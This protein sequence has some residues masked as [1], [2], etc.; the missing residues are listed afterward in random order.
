MN[1]SAPTGD[2]S[3]ATGE[4]LSATA[5]ASGSDRSIGAQWRGGG[6]V[7]DP[8]GRILLAERSDDRARKLRAVVIVDEVLDTVEREIASYPPGRGGGLVGPI[9]LP[10]IT[11][12]VPDPQVATGAA[13]RASSA[14]REALTMIQNADANI[15]FKGILH[16]SPRATSNPSGDGVNV[17]AD[18][19]RLAPWFGRYVNPI[20]TH[21]YRRPERHEV[22]LP[23][24]IMSVYVSERIAVGRAG[25]YPA[26]VQVLPIGRDVT[27]LAVVLGGRV[28]PLGTVDVDGMVFVSYVV[29]AGGFELNLLFAPTY[30][31]QSPIVLVE[32]GSAAARSGLPITT[33]PDHRII[34]IPISW[35][36]AVPE[37]SRLEYALRVLKD[38]VAPHPESRR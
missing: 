20:V 7:V 11:A 29:Q 27:R 28:S 15:E 8:E 6:L 19:L 24:G 32:S 30:P 4:Y 21:Q 35:D 5:G 25:V 2:R 1:E 13:F 31:F 33:M 14:F 10:V 16:S 22:L 37:R 26:Q 3:R 34:S 9:G 38:G 17:F 18:S 23:S 12:F 36:L